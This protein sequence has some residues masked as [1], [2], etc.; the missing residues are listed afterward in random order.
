MPTP[1]LVLVAVTASVVRQV[2][3]GIDVAVLVDVP[4]RLGLADVVLVAVVV[5]AVVVRRCSVEVRVELSVQ[6]VVLGIKVAV[7]DNVED[8]DIVKLMLVEVVAVM[9]ETVDVSV[10]VIVDV[11]MNV[12]ELDT[13]E[14]L[15]VELCE[16]E[17]DETVLETVEVVLNISTR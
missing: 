3:V 15:V 14:L 7:W 13:V 17:V 9:V 2:L 1:V 11:D 10:C 6:D 8:D 16:M 4:S 5:V 12:E